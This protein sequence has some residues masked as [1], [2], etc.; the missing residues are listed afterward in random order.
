MTAP[1]SMML[2]DPMM[3]GPATAKIVA[4]G[5]MTVPGRVAQRAT[6]RFSLASILRHSS[7]DEFLPDF[8]S[9][10]PTTISPFISTSWQTTAREEILMS[11]FLGRDMHIQS[12]LAQCEL[13][14]AFCS[15]PR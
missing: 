6:R 5:W 13:P 2:L 15:L 4:R 7:L 10:D 3:I 11:S 1:S 14:L 8:R 12:R 9:P